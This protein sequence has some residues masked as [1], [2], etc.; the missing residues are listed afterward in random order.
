M[1]QDS[2]EY[3]DQDAVKDEL[4][5]ARRLCNRRGWP[6]ID[7]TRRSI[8]GDCGHGAAAHGRLA[9][10]APPAGVMPAGVMHPHA[11]PLVLA[12]ASAARRA[13]LAAAGGAV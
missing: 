8:E 4:L 13:L 7:V 5:W 12:S 1:R 3:I 6:V 2:S 10:P 9:R 11:P